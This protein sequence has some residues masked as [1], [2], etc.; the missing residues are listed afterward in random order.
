[1]KRLSH[2]LVGFLMSIIVKFMNNSKNEFPKYKTCI[3]CGKRYACYRT[4]Q[5][6]NQKYCSVDCMRKSDE[7]IS[8]QKNACSNNKWWSNTSPEEISRI[9]KARWNNIHTH[10]KYKAKNGDRLNVSTNY[11]KEYR[12]THNVCEICGCN[13]MR[14]DEQIRL[15]VD[16]DHK[17]KEFRGLLCSKCNRQLGWYENNKEAIEEYLSKQKIRGQG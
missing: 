15:C 4:K 1:M 16:H 10:D 7:Y 2:I 6:L 11:I 9:L 3:E 13:N 8:N 14:N 12:K 17:T 5:Y